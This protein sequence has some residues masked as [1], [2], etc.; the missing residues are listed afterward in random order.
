MMEPALHVNGAHEEEPRDDVLPA[1]HGVH[2][3]APAAEK[4]FAPQSEQLETPPTEYRP[5][6]HATHVVAP[7]PLLPR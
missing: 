6:S 1:G 2:E 5:L 3:E 7:T 4:V